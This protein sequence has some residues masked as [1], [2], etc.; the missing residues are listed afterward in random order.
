MQPEETRHQNNSVKNRFVL[1]AFLAIA[2]YFLWTEHQAHVIEFLPYVLLFSC[3][4]LHFF[5]HR[6][7]GHCG[8]NGEPKPGQDPHRH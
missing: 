4:F 3:L 8:E 7:G 6:G 1:F 2:A 5:M